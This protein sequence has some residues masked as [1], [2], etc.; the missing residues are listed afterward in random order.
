M[1]KCGV[2]AI[3]LRC[4]GF[5]NVDLDAAREFGIEVVRV[6]AYSPYAV[7]EHAVALLLM[8]N[9]HLHK[10]YNRV[11]EGNFL[12]HGLTGF[13]LNGKTVGVVGTGEIGQVFCKIMLGFGCRVV[14]YDP[15]ISEKCRELGVEYLDWSELLQVADVISLHCPLMPQTHHM[16]DETALSQMK[17]GVV[18]INT[19]RGG[20]VDT[21]AVIAALKSRKL[22][23]LGLD[24][25]EEEGELFF[26]DMSDQVIDD[27]L[28]MRLMTFPN[29]VVTGH[30]AFLTH[31]ALTNIATTTL[32]NLSDIE[33]GNECPNKV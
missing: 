5:N 33:A 31:E 12:L 15:V 26:E 30:Q 16:V 18:L 4:A 24:V 2:R 27:D 11:R 32:S 23:A 29:V 1:A 13:D 6:P 28:L 14:A 3:A 17:P 10:A 21:Q 7:A 20:L 8:L 22:G 19:S 9:R 25:Y